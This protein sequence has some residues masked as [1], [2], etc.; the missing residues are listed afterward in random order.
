MPSYQISLSP[1]RRAGARFV[2]RTLHMLQ[3]A[4]AD[5]KISSGVK[6]T[7]I[8]RNLGVHR[9][10][11]NRELRGHRD[12]SIFR[13]GEY[14]WALGYNIHIEFLKYSKSADSNKKLTSSG[15]TPDTISEEL[16]DELKNYGQNYQQ[17]DSLSIDTINRSNRE[18]R[19]REYQEG[20]NRR[21]A[22]AGIRPYP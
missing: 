5:E 19:N 4:Y 22:G 10:I 12:I 15:A 1:N 11:V 16:Q 6:Q 2:G 21:G 20:R 17:E 18:N 13:I 14:A 3:K 7:D 9:S 8:A